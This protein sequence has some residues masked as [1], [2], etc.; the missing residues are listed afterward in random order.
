M[1]QDLTP[2]TPPARKITPALSP[3]LRQQLEAEA[4]EDEAIK[5]IAGNLALREEARAV[6]PVLRAAATQKAGPEGV[7][8]VIGKRLV[9]YPQ[10]ARSDAE[11]AAWWADYV[12]ILSDVPWQ[13][14]EAAMLTWV[15]DPKS[16]F[17][18]KPGQLHALAMASEFPAAKTFNRAA[19]AMAVVK[20]EE[21]RSKPPPS[22]EQV[23]AVKSMLSGFQAKMA[24]KDLSKI[25]PPMPSTAGKPD[26]GGLTPAMRALMARQK[27]GR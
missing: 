16:E 8:E 18:P 12:D 1:R 9:L 24:E 14:L 23:A 21:A 26:Q 17:M 22:P 2:A 6:L 15:K 3:D 20:A 5:T 27:E 4:N 19:K 13:A 11:W 10:P 25:S 7:G